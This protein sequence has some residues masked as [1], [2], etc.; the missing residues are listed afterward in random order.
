VS[1]PS[2]RKHQRKEQLAWSPD[3]DK[4][5]LYNLDEDWTQA[6]DLADKMPDKLAQMK[7]LFTMEFAKNN[8]F[9]VGGGLYVMAVRPDLR[10]STPYTEWTF[11]GDMQVLH[12]AIATN[13]T[14]PG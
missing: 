12:L 8:G 14:L 7:D 5:E 13:R 3:N 9:P 6:N 2:V 4:W 10:A 11:A 1:E